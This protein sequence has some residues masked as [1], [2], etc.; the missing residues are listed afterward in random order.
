MKLL[1]K[2][3]MYEL[4]Q[5]LGYEVPKLKDCEY[6]KTKYSEKMTI[7][8]SL[9]DVDE[10]CYASFYHSISMNY[11][12]ICINLWDAG[13]YVEQSSSFISG[14]EYQEYIK[15]LYP[16]ELSSNVSQRT[17]QEENGK[18]ERT[19]NEKKEEGK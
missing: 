1:N 4:I 10:V 8:Y 9:H 6:R 12:L 15:K 2:K 17:E 5:M 7:P 14:N 3:K 16:E 11:I 19:E 18:T 13:N